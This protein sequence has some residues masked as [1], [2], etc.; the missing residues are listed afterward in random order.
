MTAF[1]PSIM[2]RATLYVAV[3]LAGCG[4]GVSSDPR[5]VMDAA[6]ASGTCNM[7]EGPIHAYTEQ[8]ELEVLLIGRWRRC[9]GPPMTDGPMAGLE[10]LAD[11]TYFKLGT[12]ASG[13]LVRN[14]GFAN[15]G[16]WLTE[17]DSPTTVHLYV[18]PDSPLGGVPAFEDNPRKMAMA[19]PGQHR[20]I[21]I[22]A[23]EP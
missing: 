14:T 5:A 2:A 17:Q 1:T 6:L 18:H 7:P 11:H 4:S 23:L 15:E 19:V 22:Y 21:V 9:S 13:E 16:D 3:G 8:S 12:D 10:L 20:D